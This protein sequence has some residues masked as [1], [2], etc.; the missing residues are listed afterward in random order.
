M[1]RASLHFIRHIW[2]TWEQIKVTVICPWI[3]RRNEL[4]IPIVIT[5][6]ECKNY[7]VSCFSDSFLYLTRGFGTQ[8]TFS[9]M[10]SV[11]FG[12]C[13]STCQ[14]LLFFYISGQG[15]WLICFSSFCKCVYM[16]L[17][18]FVFIYLSIYLYWKMC[19]L[20]KLMLRIIIWSFRIH[21]H[22]VVV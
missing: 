22:K 18:L 21:T 2:N 7:F 4:L 10:Y 14:I 3:F 11:L 1:S 13:S 19:N 6:S 16:Y 20:N 9:D 8:S 17:F 12:P 15:W 5:S